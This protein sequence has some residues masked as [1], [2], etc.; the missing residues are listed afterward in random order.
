LG[1]RE[2]DTLNSRTTDGN[3]VADEY[4]IDPSC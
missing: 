1:H 2:P 4:R 3:H